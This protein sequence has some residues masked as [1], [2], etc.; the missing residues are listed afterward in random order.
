M[1]FSIGLAKLHCSTLSL[2][3]KLLHISASSWRTLVWKMQWPKSLS[4]QTRGTMLMGATVNVW[5]HARRQVSTDEECVQ[6][7]PVV[8]LQMLLLQIQLL[9]LSNRKVCGIHQ[10]TSLIRF[11][12]LYSC[13][14]VIDKF[15]IQL[16]SSKVRVIKP[17]M[18]FLHK[19]KEALMKHSK[20]SN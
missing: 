19:C 10:V 18:I 11:P 1:P 5:I 3:R 2:W 16:L 7:L 15:L 20:S 4:R 9:L 8:F 6:L 14:K 12:E 13:T 17:R